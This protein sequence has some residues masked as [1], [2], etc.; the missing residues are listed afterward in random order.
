MKDFLLEILRDPVTGNALIYDKEKK[1]L[2]TGRGESLYKIKDDVPLI[3][4]DEPIPASSP[5]HQ[6]VNTSFNYAH[7]YQKDSE[8]YDYFKN[9]E[10]S[11]TKT[12]IERLHKTIIKSI[13]DNAD[14]IIDVGCGNGWLAGY[15]IKKNLKVISMDISS[16]NPV[17]ALRKYPG[18]NHAA[19]V[20][21][22]F[23]FP[24]KNNSIDCIVASEIMEHVHDPKLFVQILVEKLKPGG[25]L[26]ITT[27]Y[28]EKIEYYLCVHCNL[29]TP[30]NAHLH[31]F[32]KDNIKDVI[33]NNRVK[34]KTKATANRFLIRTRLNVLFR[35]LP[36][37]L[38]NIFDAL[39]NKIINSPTRFII[40]IVKE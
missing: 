26:I 8:V 5:L 17:K 34:W 37:G 11:A 21:D 25:K 27:P 22:V 24:V 40:E 1:V 31:S 14:L 30:K 19:L 23:H 29:P 3:L 36:A 20:A 18:E 16:I 13:P 32:N 10:I 33:G 7:H 4:I 15:F 28:N 2:N 12:E 9:N 39:M 35:F 38:W 6:N